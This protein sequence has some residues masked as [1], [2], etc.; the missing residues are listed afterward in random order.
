MQE[1]GADRNR[2]KINCWVFD[3]HSEVDVTFLRDFVTPYFSDVFYA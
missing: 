3:S 1:Y 2:Q